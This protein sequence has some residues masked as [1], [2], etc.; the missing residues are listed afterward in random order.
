MELLK[1]VEQLF[2]QYGYIVLLFGIPLDAIALPIPPGN[3]TLTYAGFL[4]Y[5]GVLEPIPAFLCAYVGATLGVTATYVLGYCLGMPLVER[6]G[7]WI[8]LRVKH[9]EKTKKTFHKYGMRMLLFSYFMPG[10]R[11]FNGYFAGLV[12]IPFRS[13]VLYAYTG[14]FLWVSV[15]FGIG[16]IF[17]N[18][19]TYIFSLVEKFT[20]SFII[21]VCCLI[22]FYVYIKRKRRR[23]S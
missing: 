15:F 12:R 16:F 4:A 13:F 22:C 23:P 21:V 9:L 2:A 19:W 10:V 8:F 5:K 18:Q 3:T 17:G 11:Q 20:V 1:H 7:K 14:A 6:Y